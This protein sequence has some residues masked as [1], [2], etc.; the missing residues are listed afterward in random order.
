MRKRYAIE[1][2]QLF[3]KN[4]PD[5]VSFDS[6]LKR[7]LL[8]LYWLLFLIQTGIFLIWMTWSDP[9]VDFVERCIFWPVGSNL[10]SP[11]LESELKPT[12]KFFCMPWWYQVLIIWLFYFLIILFT[13]ADKGALHTYDNK[14]LI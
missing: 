14:I 1:S 6:F 2:C 9:E 10:G 5:L 13:V 4:N 7:I 12:S 8:L 3:C 11:N